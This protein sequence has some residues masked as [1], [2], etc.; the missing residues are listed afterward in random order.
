[1]KIKKLIIFSIIVVLTAGVIYF[2]LNNPDSRGFINNNINKL[3]G[4][5]LNNKFET[6]IK[7]GNLSTDY[8]IDKV[9]SDIDKFKLNTLNV[10][11]VVNVKDLSSSNMTV[12]KSSEEKA[13]ELLKSLEGKK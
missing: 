12:D 5:T 10:P 3:E 9:V 8:N 2:V 1:M 6:K 4:K 11:I 13:K 7:S